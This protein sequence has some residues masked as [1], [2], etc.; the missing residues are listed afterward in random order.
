MAE[1]HHGGRLR[2]AAARY[3][4]PLAEWLDLS[5]GINPVGWPVPPLPSSCWQ[6]LPEDDDGL[7]R[8]AAA[9]YGAA[10]LLPTAGSQAALQA[11]P[12]LR[13]TGRIGIL[14]PGYAEHAAA[15][16]RQGHEVIGL[17]AEAIPR[18][19]PGL[20]VLLLINPNN[21]GGERFSP[22]QLRRWRSLLARRGGWLV[23]DEAFMD[24]T[25]EQSLAAD[26]GE[27]GL[28]V[29]RSLGKFFGL[30]GA[31]VGFV[32]A[33]PQLLQQLA[34]V[35]GPWA[36]SGPARAVARMALADSAWQAETRARLVR[37]GERLRNL[38]ACFG[39]PPA[40][41]AGLFQ[42]CPTVQAGQWHEA[43]AS[44][45]ILTRLFSEPPA[46]RFGLPGDEVAWQ[47]LEQALSGLHMNL[48]RKVAE[49]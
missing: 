30:A 16:R 40:G 5:T 38:L 44:R 36:V 32:L 41:G 45:G 1:L 34:G 13:A 28:I 23:V 42:Y 37:E 11:L 21:P 35:L 48:A 20:D 24:A 14:A 43:L 31:R 8:T 4:I 17:T 27:P 6:R 29:L 2:E 47:R 3:G 7:E 22:G 9:Y 39:L 49:C 19:L 18:L 15:W 26:C 12:M 33:W 46:L 25:P 10:R